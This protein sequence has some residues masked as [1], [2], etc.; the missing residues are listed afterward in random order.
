MNTEKDDELVVLLHQLGGKINYLPN[1]G[2]AGDSLIACATFQFF[3]RNNISYS[4]CSSEND[5]EAGDVFVFGGGGNFGGEKSRVA[6]YLRKYSE[7]VKAFILLPHTLFGAKDLLTSLPSNVFLFCRERVSYDYAKKHVTNA[8]VYLHDDMVFGAD[9]QPLLS[10]DAKNT[11]PKQFTL[12]CMRRIF[13]K[14]EDDFG[15][16]LKSYINYLFWNLKGHFSSPKEQGCALNAFRDDVEKTTIQ[17]P[18]DN[19][20]IS[21]LYELS[22]CEPSLSYLSVNRFLNHIKNYD[23]INTNRLHVAIAAAKLG[24]NVNL[25]GNNYFKIRAIYEYSLKGKY[26]NV[27]WKE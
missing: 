22:A 2:N 24:K 4:V 8:K 5:I 13:G 18:I 9:L 1:P 15:I 7:R 16:S 21:A 12:E 25:Y 27:V 14:S 3:E 19:V 10:L 23:I 6:Y 17:L 20:D 26:A 11:A